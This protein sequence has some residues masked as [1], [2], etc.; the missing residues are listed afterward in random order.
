[1]RHQR[2]LDT[3]RERMGSDFRT[4]RRSVFAPPSCAVYV[5]LATATEWSG[6]EVCGS[7]ECG[8][9]DSGRIWRTTFERQP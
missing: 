7:E 3:L 4:Y 1:M 9:P 8:A 6:R 2:H 5:R